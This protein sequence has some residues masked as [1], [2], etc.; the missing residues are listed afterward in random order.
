MKPRWNKQLVID[1]QTVFASERGKRVLADLC[2]RAP[3]LTDSINITNGID[4]NKLL[5]QEGRRSVVLHIYKM[6]GRDPNE[7]VRERAVIER[8]GE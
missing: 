8:Q 1:Y 3:L 5:V 4:V 2:K 7:E 6:L